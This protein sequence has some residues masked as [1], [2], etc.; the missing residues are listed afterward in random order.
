MIREKNQLVNENQLLKGEK[1]Q[2][3]NETQEFWKKNINRQMK[4]KNFGRKA[5]LSK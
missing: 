1:D 3:A 5:S 2:L 4:L